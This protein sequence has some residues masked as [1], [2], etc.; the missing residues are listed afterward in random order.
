MEPMTTAA[1]ISAGASI[2]GGI[3][4]G[5]QAEQARRM[6]EYQQALQNAQMQRQAQAEALAARMGYL[7]GAQGQEASLAAQRLAAMDLGK[8]QDFESLQAR[9][10][11]LS[12][13]AGTYR[14]PAGLSPAASAFAASRPSILA[15]L[16]SERFR[17]SVGQDATQRS[18][19][20]FTSRVNELRRNPTLDVEQRAALDRLEQLANQPLPQAPTTGRGNFFTNTLLPAL[21]GG[22]QVGANM[23]MMNQMLGPQASP[24]QRAVVGAAAPTPAGWTIPRGTFVQTPETISN[25]GGWAS[26]LQT[27]FAPSAPAAPPFQLGAYRPSF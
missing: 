9:R 6:Q 16:A 11:G 23:Y 14:P 13:L 19:G 24:T 21:A 2:L 17:A 5:K 25:F 7:T 27:A 4:K 10:E 26:G 18:I 22:A 15:P 12:Q 3:G 20:D 8:L 1:L